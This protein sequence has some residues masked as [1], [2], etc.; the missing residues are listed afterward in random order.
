MEC[1]EVWGVGG[2]QWIQQGLAAQRK[3]REVAEAT[4]RRARKVDK[5]QFVD[6]LKFMATPSDLFGHIEHS[7][8][9]TDL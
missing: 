2:E 3:G 7:A 4:L 9:R 8:T 6:D 1:I 5:K